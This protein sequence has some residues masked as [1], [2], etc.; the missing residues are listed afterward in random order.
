MPG[1]SLGL[2]LNSAWRFAGA[3]RPVEAP[4]LLFANGEQGA[5]YDPSDLSTMSQDSAGTI[6]AAVDSPVGRIADKSGNDRHL[7][8]ATTSQKPILRQSGSQYYLQFDGVDDTL[9]SDSIDLS[10]SDKATLMAAIY[11]SGS[12]GMMAEFSPTTDSNT[13]SFNFYRS[14]GTTM[15]L[16]SRGTAAEGADK[17]VDHTVAGFTAAV[18]TGLFDISGDLVV[19]RRNA[20]QMGTATG[21]QGAGNFGNYPLYLGARGGT[22]LRWAGRLYGLIVRSG[23]TAGDELADA[24]QWLDGKIGDTF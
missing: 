6:A 17:R 20:V 7:T 15:W 2:G 12:S 11:N 8:Q 13:G 19:A 9:V 24:E 4:A 22:A 3:V 10:G 16:S 1:L 5:W 14:G 21:D 18:H 23:L